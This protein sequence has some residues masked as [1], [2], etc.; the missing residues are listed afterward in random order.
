M[1]VCIIKGQSALA[2]HR[3]G[4]MSVSV[5][6]FTETISEYIFSVLDSKYMFTGILIEQPGELKVMYMAVID[7]PFEKYSCVISPVGISLRSDSCFLT[8]E[9]SNVARVDIST[10]AEEFGRVCNLCEACCKL[11]RPYNT[12]DKV[13]STFVPMASLEDNVDI[14]T[15]PK[16]HTSQAVTLILR[17]AL[18]ESHPSR[19][20][21]SGVNSRSM[22]STLLHRVLVRGAPDL[23]I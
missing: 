15:A 23:V 5:L 1:G 4:I 3:R 11:K 18:A 21:L 19:L 2:P 6:F 10:S 20:A 9:T 12:W 13:V 14:F 17:E 16:L 8:F 7:H 22:Y